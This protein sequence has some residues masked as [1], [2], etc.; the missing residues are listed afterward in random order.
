M[1]FYGALQAYAFHTHR[2]IPQKDPDGPKYSP[3]PGCAGLTPNVV[4][5]EAGLC[6]KEA[7]LCGKEVWFCG[8]EAWL[9]GK[10]ADPD[11][12]D[13]IIAAFQFSWEVMEAQL[14]NVI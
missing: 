9:C 13:L 14:E 11:G 5:S 3:G 4:L 7:W 10:G 6:G 1:S 2:A 12:S 8:K